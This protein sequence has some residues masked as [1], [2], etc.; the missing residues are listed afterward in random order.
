VTVPADKGDQLQL[1]VGAVETLAALRGVPGVHDAI[2]ARQP[3][4]DGSAVLAGYVIGPDPALGTTGIR[5]HLLTVLPPD[6]VPDCVIV[7][8]ELPLA[9]DGGYDLA[10]LP[11]P[12]AEQRPAD[13]HVAPRTPMERQ[14]SDVMQG[15]LSLDSISV[16]DSFFALGGSSLQAA[17]LASKLGN[18]FDVDLT[19]P[20]VFASP[21]VKGLCELIVQSL[22]EQLGARRLRPRRRAWVAVRR[23]PKRM[24]QGWRNVHRRLPRL[25]RIWIWPGIPCGAVPDSP[26]PGTAPGQVPGLLT[27]SQSTGS[28]GPGHGAKPLPQSGTPL[29]E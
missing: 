13:V 10:A 23:F 15:I 18:I 20:E 6:L 2:L 14:V 7:L 3:A 22:G 28:H 5:Q 25:L 12:Q 16:H 8:A 9:A 4:A 24:E 19:L 29:Q 11:R 26:N 1:A 21:T 17:Q 27:P